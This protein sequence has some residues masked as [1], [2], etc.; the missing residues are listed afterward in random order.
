VEKQNIPLQNQRGVM[1][2]EALISILIFSIGILAIIG[3]QVNSIKLANDSKYRADASLLANQIVGAMWAAQSSATFTTDFA[4]TAFVASPY[5]C[6][7]GTQYCAWATRVAA[8]IP[9]TGVSAPTVTIAQTTM[10]I[11]GASS[12]VTSTATVDVYW[13]MPGESTSGAGGHHYQTFTQINN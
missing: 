1:L 6:T 12:V 9:I 4:G 11:T 3:L 7:G 8:T 5:N 13:T 2:L 10:P